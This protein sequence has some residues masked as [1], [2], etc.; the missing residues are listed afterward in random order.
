MKNPHRKETFQEWIISVFSDPLVK[1][2]IKKSHLTRIQLETLLIDILSE[3]LVG[4][5]LP[6]EKKAKL[7]LVKSGV[8]RGAFNRTLSQARRNV[9][10]SIYTLILLGYLGIFETPSIDPYLEIAN[11]IRD[12]KDACGSLWM[13]KEVRAEHLRII[14]ALEREI[15][16]GLETLSEPKAMAHKT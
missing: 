15:E 12:Y 10:K 2:L 6:Y 8:T 14:N 16:K 3:K 9:I 13:S 1:L 5:Y 11:K 7:R 4:K